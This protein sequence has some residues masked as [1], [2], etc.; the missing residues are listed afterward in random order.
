M[1]KI[2]CSYKSISILSAF[3]CFSLFVSIRIISPMAIELGKIRRGIPI[4][5][6]TALCSAKLPVHI[7]SATQIVLR[8]TKIR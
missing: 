8:H 7:A 1:L 4:A 5:S 6:L 3:S 2:F